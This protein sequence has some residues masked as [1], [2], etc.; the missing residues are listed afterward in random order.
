[1]TGTSLDGLDAA[2]IEVTGRGHDL[3]VVAVSAG[4]A[5]FGPD[6]DDLR[7]FAAGHPLS[8][9]R[10]AQLASELALRH[11]RLLTERWPGA[12]PDLVVLHG[13][14]VTHA[15]PRSWQLVDPWPVAAAL[16]CPVVHDLRGA[17]LAA[18][19][20]GAPIT[21]VADA[22]LYRTSVPDRGRLVIVNLGGF[23]NA[24]L[25]DEGGPATAFGFDCCPCNHLLDAASRALLGTPFDRD[26]ATAEKGTPVPAVAS[27]LRRLAGD[28]ARVGRS[29]GD[30]DEHR[31]AAIEAARTVARDHGV[32]DALATIVEAVAL[33]IVDSMVEARPP[34]SDPAS[35][36]RVILAGGGTRNRA[37]VRVLSREFERR[38]EVT[39]VRSGP[40]AGIEPTIR[41]AAG[42]A[43]LGLLAADGVPITSRLTTGRSESP[44]PDGCWT[45]GTRP[46]GKHR[47]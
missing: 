32:E 16:A 11:V 20:Q 25:L 39:E 43:V 10:I 13:Q 9:D 24:T 5:P 12:T 2:R 45:G 41:E 15:P 44:P 29:G 47:I 6:L 21:P 1:M 30:G 34:I 4:S 18:G 40:T 35:I 17:D 46:E 27:R 28:L 37:L 42:M 38:T 8:A 22:I 26:G 33:A 14:T 23:A 36:G 19:G 7:A 31:E 3:Q